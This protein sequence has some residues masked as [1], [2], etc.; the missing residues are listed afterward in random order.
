MP[1]KAKKTTQKK[2]AKKK[3]SAK[4][5]KKKKRT[6]KSS[7]KAVKAKKVEAK[8]TAKEPKE[9]KEVIKLA[10][11]KKGDTGSPEVQ[12]ALLTKRIDDLSD[13]LKDHKKDKHSRRGLLG[14][15][16]KRRK[17]LI[18]LRR[19]DENRYRHIT[20]KLGLSR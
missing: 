8:K 15:V 18:Y 2:A 6:T 3:P 1:K 17:L 12:I 4:S 20:E 14:L 10:A 7:P 19:K 16:N 13:H 5:V 11:L 9:K